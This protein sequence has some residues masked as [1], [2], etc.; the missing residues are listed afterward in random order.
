MRH[1]LAIP[2]PLSRTSAVAAPPPMLPPSALS[3]LA[4]YAES[5]SGSAQ[6]EPQEPKPTKQSH[7]PPVLSPRVTATAGQ[8]TSS[9]T[10]QSI[11]PV[12]VLSLSRMPSRAVLQ[13]FRAPAEGSRLH[14]RY[15]RLCARLEELPAFPIAL[16]M[17]HA[18][19]IER[20]R[21]DLEI[22]YLD[23][24]SGGLLDAYFE[25]ILD[26]FDEDAYMIE[27]LYAPK[28]WHIHWDE[29][30]ESHYFES[31]STGEVSWSWPGPTITSTAKRG[32][33]ENEKESG[34]LIIPSAQ[35]AKAQI[36]S[37]SGMEV[38][39]MED[40][41]EPVDS[42]EVT[43]EAES[44]KEEMQQGKRLL[45]DKPQTVSISAKSKRL[46]G[47]LQKWHAAKAELRDEEV[48]SAEEVEFAR[49]Q[50][51]AQAQA[52]TGNPNFAPVGAVLTPQSDPITLGAYT[53]AQTL[54]A[55]AACATVAFVFPGDFKGANEVFTGTSGAQ[56]FVL[57]AL[58]TAGLV[59]TVLFLAVEK[60]RVTFWAPMAI[61]LYVFTAHLVS[62]PYTNTSINPARSFGAAFVS[63][64]WDNHALFWFAPLSGAALAALLY[65]FYKYVEYEKFNPGQDADGTAVTTSVNVE[66]KETIKETVKVLKED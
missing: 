54:G 17:Q 37:K 35:S 33:E 31:I 10:T 34:S 4:S 43:N 66:V 61:G 26:Q 11:S 19:E 14:T 24:K 18:T 2:K 42:L 20:F 64:N 53:I 63:G 36:D 51:W 1:R 5:D 15:T 23:W 58:L 41:Q 49:L 55:T 6:D 9:A 57:E 22:R 46:A 29:A 65:N 56:A 48:E 45:R 39:P 38:R 8:N 62:I 40:D 21:V 3:G 60:S 32:K 30:T 47:M 13:K 16:S 7:T 50:A 28:D 12:A 52:G 59:L 27:D 44:M 25:A